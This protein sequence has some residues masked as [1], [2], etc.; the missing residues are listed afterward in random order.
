[1]RHHRRPARDALVCRID[2]VTL[3]YRPHHWQLPQPAVRA[4]DR[5]TRSTG[6]PG[7]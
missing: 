7:T 4:E 2:P 1:M 6:K 5:R 3:P